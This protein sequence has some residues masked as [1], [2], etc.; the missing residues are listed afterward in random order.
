MIAVNEIFDS[1]QGEGWFQGMPATFLRLQGC[2]LRCPWCDTPQ[3]LDRN[4]DLTRDVEDVATELL[5]HIPDVVVVTGGEPLMQMRPLMKLINTLR[6][7]KIF[8]LETN[9]TFQILSRHWF[10]YITV[11]PKP[12][13]YQV[14]CPADEIKLVVDKID[15]LQKAE[16]LSKFANLISLQPLDN[17]PYITKEIIE[18]LIL[19]DRQGGLEAPRWKLSLQL[20]K[21]IGV[22]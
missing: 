5:A 20:H 9:G 17:N 2:N 12:P 22:R 3:A 21:M 10:Q 1:I 18:Y 16:E 7:D 19:R 11:S 4:G 13:E 14:R 6:H 8:H 15:V